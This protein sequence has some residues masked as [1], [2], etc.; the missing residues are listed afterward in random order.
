MFKPIRSLPLIVVCGL[1]AAACT[2]AAPTN[3]APSGAATGS[4]SSTPDDPRLHILNV[5][6]LAADQT[7]D[8]QVNTSGFSAYRYYPNVYETLVQYSADGQVQ[9]MLAD[10]WEIS[11][12][13]QT[14][15]FHLRPGTKFSDGT[16]FN[17]A[18]VKSSFD[19]YRTIGKGSGI[20]NFR[21]IDRVTVNDD[22]TIE[23]HLTGPNVAIMAA[24]GSWQGAIWVSPAAV[25]ANAVGGDLAQA[26][27]ANHSAGT[28]PYIIEN[29]EP[30]VRVVLARNPNYREAPRANSI[31][32]VVYSTLA[33]PGTLRQQLEAGDLDLAESITPEL[34]APL[35]NAKGVVVK[36]DTTV[37]AAVSQTVLMNLEK[38]PLDNV[39]FRKALMASVDYNGL[40]SAWKGTG[41]VAQGPFPQTFSPWF[42]AADVVP[43][44]FDMAKAADSMRA[45]GLSVPANPPITFKLLWQADQTAQR[46][47]SQLLAEQWAKLGV[48]LEIIQASPAVWGAEVQ[49]HTFDMAWI[50]LPIR[51]PDPDSA[52][53]LYVHTTSY[54]PG[55]FNPGIK[56]P[57]FDELID[58]AVATSDV[59]QR[60]SYY[61]Q[62][63]RQLTEGVYALYLVNKKWAY[64]YGTNVSGVVWNPVYGPFFRVA[65]ISKTAPAR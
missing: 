44:Q 32:R 3:A 4:S 48:K 31:T 47:M 36:L 8:P 28:G 2:S 62:L 57:A 54:A 34:V 52:M 11:K 43:Y 41:V 7:W 58:K 30:N 35:Q 21:T 5:G 65:D 49:G 29:R 24:F 42:S 27:L 38:K 25:Q 59:A 19:R 33:E 12:D 56:V 55:G 10:K 63:A 50:Q 64:A 23:F 53:R 22:L 51:T 61:N 17:A 1:L 9:P 26:W 46:D 6:T 20:A 60:K 39:N 15:T 45:A 40:L 37:A 13:V 16:P 14:Y 18:A